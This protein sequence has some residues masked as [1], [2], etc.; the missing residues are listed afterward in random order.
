MISSARAGAERCDLVIRN[1]SAAAVNISLAI[2][3]AEPAVDGSGIVLRPYDGVAFSKS[4]GYIVPQGDIT[5]IGS[6]AGP[7]N[8]AVFERYI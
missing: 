4:Q 2:S 5:A 6:A 8:V 7:T 1:M 3:D